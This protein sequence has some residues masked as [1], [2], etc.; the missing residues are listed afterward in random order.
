[1]KNHLRPTPATSHAPRALRAPLAAIAALAAFAA[2]C[3]C[4]GGRD[5]SLDESLLDD[6]PWEARY[7]DD[8]FDRH[9]E[10]VLLEPDS[11]APSPD[12]TGAPAVK[13]SGGTVVEVGLWCALQ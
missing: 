5:A 8:E 12:A 10:G 2:L 9:I 3:A 7:F 11:A 4:G 1:M 13:P 6:A